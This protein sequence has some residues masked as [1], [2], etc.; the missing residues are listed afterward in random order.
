MAVGS[1]SRPDGDLLHGEAA[2]RLQGEGHAQ[3]GR[4]RRDGRR[5]TAAPA[6]RRSARGRNGPSPS[7]ELGSN[8]QQLVRQ[9]QTRAP[10]GAAG[11]AR[12]S[13]H[14][15][16]PGLRPGRHALER[17]GR[18][19]LQ[20][21]V[22]DGILGHGDAARAQPPRQ[23]GDQAARRIAGQRI[24]ELVDR[25]AQLAA[26][27]AW[28]MSSI[29]RISIQLVGEMREMRA[30]PDDRLGLGGIPASITK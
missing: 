20:E 1:L 18:Q 9:H 6:R 7:V 11:R 23:R 17:P 3:L 30:V 4:Q 14:H 25:G 29:G 15:R 10:R 28:D 13:C 16:Q 5:R 12:G 24:D 2:H 19:R 8:G 22:L 26:A 21:R 27:R